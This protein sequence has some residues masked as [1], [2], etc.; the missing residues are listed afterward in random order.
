M[1]GFLVSHPLGHKEM[2]GFL[3]S[4]PLG[5]L[6]GAGRDQSQIRVPGCQIRASN[7]NFQGSPL[8]RLGKNLPRASHPLGGLPGAGRRQDIEPQLGAENN[9]PGGALFIGASGQLF[10][11]VS[12]SIFHVGDD[13]A[14]DDTDSPGGIWKPER[15]GG[16]LAGSAGFL[17]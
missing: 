13:V 11:A 15:S 14:G 2:H 9:C 12:W 4:H 3:V 10:L 7:L 8:P 5:G 6:P 1:H 17:H 16:W